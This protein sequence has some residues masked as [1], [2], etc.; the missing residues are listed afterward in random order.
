M[1]KEALA[2]IESIHAEIAQCG[3]AMEDATAAGADFDSGAMV[4]LWV[5]ID[6]LLRELCRAMGVD[7]DIIE[8]EAAV[9]EIIDAELERLARA[10]A[11]ERSH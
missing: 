5:R 2:A 10:Y 8:S 11:G 1:D 9:Q 4:R 3:R 6:E 7:A